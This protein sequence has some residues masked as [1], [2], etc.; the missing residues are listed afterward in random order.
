MGWCDESAGILIVGTVIGKPNDPAAVLIAATHSGAGKTTATTALIRA[1]RARG[2]RTQPF[3]LGPDFIDG[4]YHAEAADRPAVNLDLWMMGEDGVRDAFQRSARDADIAVIEAMGALYDG[5]GGGEVGSAAEVAKLLDLPVLLVLDVWGMTRTAAAVLE[6]M[7]GFDP[8]VRIAG[9][10]LNR[11]GGD[12]HR[13][14]IEATLPAD[15]RQLVIGAIPHDARLE[16][17][18][19]HLGLLTAQENGATK[20]ARESAQLQAGRQLDLDRVVQMAGFRRDAWR[21]EQ[22]P[23]ASPPTPRGRLAI[24]RDSAFCFYYEDNLRL[25]ME[26]GFE[27]VPF[28]PTVDPRLPER[29][30]AVYIG[31]GYPES[32]A[33]ELAANE[34]LAASLREHAAKGVPI[35]GECGGLVYL[36]RSLVDFDGA[37][38]AMSG[39]LPLDVELD[40]AH[41]AISYVQVRTR[42]RS[43]L[44]DAG[45]VVRGQEFHQSRVAQADLEA[46]FFELTTSEGATRRDGYLKGSVLASYVHLHFASAPGIVD[47]LLEAA[48]G[49]VR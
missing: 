9:C 25:L 23:S 14:M 33:A 35:Y 34:S 12:R 46:D 6:G 22:T 41:L 38:Y 40:A 29:V 26:A 37:H 2:L 4:A 39:V 45:V 1:L 36:S 44:G 7:R 32:F 18:E 16:I 31:G 15:L 21:A 3:K 30:D 43:P 17:R 42:T 27:L 8:D 10:I 5:A 47:N 19:R 24:A 11:V 28:R 49:A 48:L 13:Q 20:Q